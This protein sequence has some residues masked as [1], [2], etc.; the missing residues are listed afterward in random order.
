M[1]HAPETAS[2]RK[3]KKSSS[4]FSYLPCKGWQAQC[5]SS[6]SPPPHK[7]KAHQDFGKDWKAQETSRYNTKCWDT[8]FK[9]KF[10]PSSLILLE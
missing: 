9:N 6:R 10:L 3:D 4:T 2:A 1:S 8:N 5:A 7:K